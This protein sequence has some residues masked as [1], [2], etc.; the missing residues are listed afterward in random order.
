ME[1]FSARLCME[2]SGES[3]LF[4]PIRTALT[5]INTPKQMSQP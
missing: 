1:Q 4:L 2:K 3:A 5:I